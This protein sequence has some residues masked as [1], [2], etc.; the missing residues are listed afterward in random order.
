M[1]GDHVTRRLEGYSTAPVY[2][3]A[4]ILTDEIGEGCCREV[5]DVPRWMCERDGR[6]SFGAF[7]LLADS[8][9]GWAIASRLRA[10]QS[11]VTAHLR[12]E[13]FR[14]IGRD[15]R[16]FG[17][18]ATA[19]HVDEEA[20][21][22]TAEL[23]DGDQ[24]PIGHAT[25]R[26]AQLDERPD[27]AER[28]PSPSHDGAARGGTEVAVDDEL[29]VALGAR[30]ESTAMITAR[31]R[32]RTANSSGAVHGGVVAMIGER[33]TLALATEIDP[34][35]R[36]LELDVLYQ[37]RVD[38]DESTVTARADVVSRTRRFLVTTGTVRRDDGRPAALVRAVHARSGR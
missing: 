17:A 21:F 3:D 4:G 28:P 22:G 31:A 2:D 9:I 15:E 14:R 33:A 26:S 34:M 1:I 18:F 32:P 36:P 11:L 20:G 6:P 12:L 29:G 5:I 37:R 23:V 25:L 10:E 27:Q 8:A 19:V 35:L 24:R 13:L 16:R 7:A 30:S 38:A